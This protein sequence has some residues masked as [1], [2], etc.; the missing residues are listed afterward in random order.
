MLL[1]CGYIEILF[2]SYGPMIITCLYFRLILGL[3]LLLWRCS[4]QPLA[5]LE[6]LL[7][8]FGAFVRLW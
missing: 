2:T 4:L 1:V 6:Q 3:L 8:Q 7:V 5:F